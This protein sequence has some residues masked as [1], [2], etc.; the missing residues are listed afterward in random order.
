M[1]QKT[2]HERSEAV[3]VGDRHLENDGTV[4]AFFD[5]GLRSRFPDGDRRLLAIDEHARQQRLAFAELPRL[6][7]R[8][9]NTRGWPLKAVPLARDHVAFDAVDAEVALVVAQMVVAAHVPVVALEVEA[10][11]VDGAFRAAV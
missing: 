11:R 6:D 2:K 9:R 7:A 10:I 4:V 5:D 8:T 1:L 3:D